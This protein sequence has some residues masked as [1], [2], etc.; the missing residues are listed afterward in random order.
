MRW[1]ILLL[2]CLLL[3]AGCELV[4]SLL[5]EWG[6]HNRAV[7]RALK[8]PNESIREEAAEVRQH[9]DQCSEVPIFPVK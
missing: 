7:D 9:A 6:G 5:G 3:F 8:S 1:I 4:N 2:L